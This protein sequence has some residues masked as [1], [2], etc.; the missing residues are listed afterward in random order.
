LVF[1]LLFIVFGLR[2]YLPYQ[3]LSIGLHVGVAALLRVIM[4]RAGVSPWIATAAATLFVFFGAGSENI[5]IAFQIT[6]TGALVLGLTQLLLADHEGPLDRRDAVGLVAGLGGL[7]CSD[8]ALVMIV[9]V[10]VLAMLA[11]RWRAAALHVLPLAVVFVAWSVGY[12][13][14]THPTFDRR[15]VEHA[16][17]TTVTATFGALGQLPFVGWVLAAMLLAGMTLAWRDTPRIERRQRLDA[18]VALSVGALAFVSIIAVNRG[19]L[20]IQFLSSS[21]YLYVVAAM[22]LPA[23][24]VS[25]DAIARRRRALGPFVLT[26]LLVGIPGNIAK[27]G[28]S[29]DPPSYGNAKRVFTSLPRMALA[30]QVPR[31]LHP[32]QSFA[33]EVTVGWLLD[34][35]QSGRIPAASPPTL[36]E[37]AN[38]T[39]RLSLEQLDG[40]P[41]SSCIPFGS[42]TRRLL[43]KGQS[44]NVRGTVGVQLAADSTH[45]AS[46]W[47]PFGGSLVAIAPTFTLRA[48]TG[49]LNL[50]IRP[51]SF[52]AALC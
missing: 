26:L 47:L 46:G 8:V 42:P 7:L 9:S 20:G 34:G 33:A 6:F 29:L 4:R 32:T 16:V 35:V 43:Q 39:L 24:A 31:S 11:R 28:R 36:F 48:V 19:G 22:L 27:T 49:P 37:F 10:G 51:Q 1:R 38:N 52:T 17:R 5:L 41:R 12:A 50:R 18:A 14:Q 21:R 3:L 45:T 44:I 30:R 40:P 13:R 2:T 23:L 15:H 25:G